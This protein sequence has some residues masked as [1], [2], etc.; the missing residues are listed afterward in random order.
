M[1]AILESSPQIV[2]QLFYIIK[3]NS[4]SLIVYI[5]LI[6]SLYT[7]ASKAIAED[8]LHFK[9]EYQ[10]WHNCKN[11]FKR[12]LYRMA[13]ITYRVSII[14]LIWLILG[15]EYAFLIILV[16]F[17]VLLFICKRTDNYAFLNCIVLTP[18]VQ[19][20]EPKHEVYVKIVRNYRRVSNF[21]FVIALC[22]NGFIEFECPSYTVSGVLNG[23]FDFELCVDYATRHKIVKHGFV[24]AL[25]CYTTFLSNFFDSITDYVIKHM[26]DSKTSN[27]IDNS[28]R[29]LI[30]IIKSHQWKDILELMLFGVKLELHDKKSQSN[31]KDWDDAYMH[32]LRYGSITIFEQIMEQR[33][34]K[35]EN[36]QVL[37]EYMFDRVYKSRKW[38]DL[39]HYSIETMDQLKE[40]YQTMNNVLE[41]IRQV[42][43]EKLQMIA[44]RFQDM[45][46]KETAFSDLFSA[47]TMIYEII[48]KQY[49]KD[50]KL[51]NTIQHIW[52]KH[53]DLILNKFSV[54]ILF[55]HMLKCFEQFDTPYR[56]QYYN[57]FYD[58]CYHKGSQLYEK[59]YQFQ[60]IYRMG[61]T[62]SHPILIGQNKLDTRLISRF[63]ELNLYIREMN[64]L[65][66]ETGGARDIIYRLV[67]GSAFSFD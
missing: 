54:E 55:D 18:L 11:Y 43:T 8:K 57:I 64:S 34:Y 29:N 15:G 42:N 65:E 44:N 49:G 32:I 47:V 50:S 3:T 19:P 16:E 7:I 66:L 26:I 35:S 40:I 10:S 60:D 46:R 51:S 48:Y 6:W 37:L 52:T 20:R 12:V 14:L 21:L 17:V 59:Q 39:S 5:S 31:P 38:N 24:L 22:I 61:K 4:A 23:F 27:N 30:G 53:S 45:I 1:E 41:N 67:P 33:V 58:I 25:I 9:K 28:D 36:D 62:M 63:R 56:Y 13:D 2:I